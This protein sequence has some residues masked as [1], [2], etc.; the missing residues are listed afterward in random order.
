MITSGNDVASNIALK[1]HLTPHVRIKDLGPLTCFL[2]LEF[3]H[4][5]SSI[6]IHQRKYATDF[7]TLARL[8]D[9]NI[10]DTPMK[11]NNKINKDDGTPLDD[12]SVI[13]RIIGSLLYLTM[14]RL[15]ITHD[16][17]TVI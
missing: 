2:G 1:H 5:K 7:I 6:R 12:P 9:A 13:R 11:L 8:D 10:F 17:H 16:V 3:V 15:D 4:S 14:T